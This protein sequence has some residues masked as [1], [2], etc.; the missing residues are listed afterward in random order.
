VPRDGFWK[1]E[2]GLQINR[3]AIWPKRS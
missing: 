2:G 1:G 3:N